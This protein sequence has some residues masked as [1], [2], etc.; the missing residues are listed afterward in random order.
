LGD[1]NV[2]VAP[3]STKPST[4]GALLL[5]EEHPEVQ[6]TYCVPGEY[7]VR[8]YSSGAEALFVDGLP[9]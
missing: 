4:L 6:I 2:V 8:D 9:G 3:M 5:A 1:N 7:N